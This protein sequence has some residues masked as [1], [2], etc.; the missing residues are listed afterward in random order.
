VQNSR[1]LLQLIDHPTFLNE[2]AVG[3]ML[4]HRNRWVKVLAVNDGW[5]EVDPSQYQLFESHLPLPRIP[6]PL[7]DLA[8]A[9]V[10]LAER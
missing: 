6:A 10:K 2:V 4:L 3:D 9:F 5:A 1:A 8:A 7:L